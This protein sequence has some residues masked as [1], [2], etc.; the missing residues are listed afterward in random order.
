MK[1][2]DFDFKIRL[3]FRLNV[4]ITIKRSTESVVTNE[5]LFCY[6]KSLERIEI[7]DR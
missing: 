7:Y 2:F 3:H 4:K 5:M 6:K 1:S